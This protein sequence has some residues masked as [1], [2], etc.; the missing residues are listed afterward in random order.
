MIRD[1]IITFFQ[2]VLENKE[3][4]L[5][6]DSLETVIMTPPSEPLSTQKRN[7]D[8]FLSFFTQYDT[9]FSKKFSIT[10]KDSSVQQ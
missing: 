8:S 4:A 9:F 6:S 2:N 1:M 10:I 7:F 3:N 5:L